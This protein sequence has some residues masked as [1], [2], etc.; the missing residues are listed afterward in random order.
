MID[1]VAVAD[2]VSTGIVVA[3]I[4]FSLIDSVRTK[5]PIDK[6]KIQTSQTCFS[7]G[8]NG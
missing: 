5:M 4:D 3:D 8:P 6:V 1:S 7:V 2:R